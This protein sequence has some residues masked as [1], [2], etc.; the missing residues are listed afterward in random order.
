ML[1]RIGVWVKNSWDFFP[2]SPVAIICRL[3]RSLSNYDDDHNDDFQKKKIG[4]MIKTTT[5]RVHH[6]F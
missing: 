4:L 2:I 6:A 1:L 5:L 3:L